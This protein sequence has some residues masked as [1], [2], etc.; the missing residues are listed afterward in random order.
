MD[1]QIAAL[2]DIIAVDVGGTVMEAA[3][4]LGSKSSNTL[5]WA[6]LALIEDT[7]QIEWRGKER[8]HEKYVIGAAHCLLSM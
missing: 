3:I 5:N 2:N 6:L 7:P 8:S 1:N 4:D